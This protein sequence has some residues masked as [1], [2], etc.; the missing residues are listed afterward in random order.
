MI[1]IQVKN[2]VRIHAS[3]KYGLKSSA[4]SYPYCA[5]NLDYYSIENLQTLMLGSLEQKGNS[6]IF[7]NQEQIFNL[8]KVLTL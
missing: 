5:F 4:F 8:G 1:A 2:T 7:F 6:K 3:A